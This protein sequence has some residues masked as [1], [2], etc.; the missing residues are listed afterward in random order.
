MEAENT[1]RWT[2]LNHF[3]ISTQQKMKKRVLRFASIRLGRFIIV[4][5]AVKR[6]FITISA[7]KGERTM[8][9][10]E[11]KFGIFIGNEM[12]FPTM[13]SANPPTVEM[14]VKQHKRNVN[15][16]QL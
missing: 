16:K 2:D 8:K 13:A 7:E 15:T 11:K 9:L 1:F 12:G 6:N 4:P 5:W 3:P 10:F 14:K